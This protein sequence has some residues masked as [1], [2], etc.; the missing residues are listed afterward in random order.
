MMTEKQGARALTLALG[1]ALSMTACGAED[2]PAEPELKL[3][4][5]AN[6][7]STLQPLDATPSPDGDSIYFIA[8]A[9][10]DE[11]YDQRAKV[12]GVYR[13]A[14]SNEGE[15]APS[16]VSSGSFVAPIGISISVDGK[17]LFVA[18]LAVETAP[19]ALGAVMM[20]SAGGGESS[21]I[22]S[23]A[24]Y[25]PQG[26]TVANVDDKEFVYFTGR[27]PE[28]GQSGA[29]RV[30]GSG[31]SVEIVASGSPF[32]DPSGIAVSPDG[33]VY[34][35]DSA[36]SGALGDL[37]ALISIKDNEASIFV[38][39]LALGMPA[40]VATT[41]DGSTIAVSALDATTRRDRVFFI[42]AG[43]AEITVFDEP[44][45]SFQ[46][47]AGLHRAHNSNFFAWA[48]SLANSSGTVYTVEL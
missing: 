5:A 31:G 9:E 38:S 2:P 30:S 22:E 43:S 28:T 8:F 42:S 48:D 18:D 6:S 40:G 25:M 16:E 26:V 45:D 19:E 3:A 14:A 46:E 4:V 12:P 13:V 15:D 36:A 1:V 39:D 7:P 11:G 41:L 29:F 35:T 24:G 47:S 27:D 37:G 21:P 10:V 33:I 20:V 17:T 34:V 44:F 32:V 23:T